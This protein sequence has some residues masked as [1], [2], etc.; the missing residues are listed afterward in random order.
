MNKNNEQVNMATLPTKNKIGFFASIMITIGSSI[1]AGIFFK[2]KSILE[3]SQNSLIFAF[4][5][6]VLAAFGVIAMALALIEIASYKNDNLSVIGWCKNFNSK[7]TYKACKNFMTYIYVP[8]TYFFMP[9]YAISSIQDSII[10]FTGNPSAALGTNADWSIMMIIAILI[11]VYFILVSG[12]SSKIGNI[13]NLFILS[14]KFFP[15]VFA[16]ILG[17]VILGTTGQIQNSAFQPGFNPITST[18]KSELLSFSS[19]TPGFGMFIA[20][21]GIFF[22]Y[23]GFYVTA[24]IKSE[25]KE[26]KKAPMAIFVGLVIV[27]VIYLLI[28]ISMSLGSD[29]SPNGFL[30]WL[31][32]KKLGW[33]YGIFQLCIGIGVLGIINGFAMW[34]PR[35]VED[36]IREKELPFSEKYITKL[37]ENRP[38]VG[39]VY[40]LILSVPTIIIFSIIGGVGYFENGYN[41]S[42][43]GTGVGTLYSFCDLMSSWTSVIVF[44]FIGFVIFGGLKNRKTKKNEVQ[45]YKYFVPFAL[46]SLIITMV[47]LFITCFEPIFNLFLLF[48]TPPVKDIIVP[49]VMSFVVLCIFIGFM[50]I[51]ECIERQINKKRQAINA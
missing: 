17:F 36:L 35:F 20:I 41:N 29:G 12:F 32:S 2:S 15:L 19:I 33:L 34:S 10:G 45:K 44:G 5:C 1:G 23:D 37:N 38:V 48:R 46:S 50:F 47:S 28:A 7:L 49:R 6:W 14:V 8:L 43:Y 22:A 42:D 3:L 26:P 24:G 27:T 51:P 4:F 18:D 16:V 9:F 40:L 11:S 21:S 13:Q 31:Q 39:I 25:L 30:S